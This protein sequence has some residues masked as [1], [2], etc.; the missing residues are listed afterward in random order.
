LPYLAIKKKKLFHV[1]SLW[2]SRSLTRKN[3][4]HE[5]CLYQTFLLAGWCASSWPQDHVTSDEFCGKNK[6]ST[7]APWSYQQACAP[8]SSRRLPAPTLPV[9][10]FGWAQVQVHVHVQQHCL[11]RATRM[12]LSPARRASN[13]SPRG[14]R[15]VV[16][17]MPSWLFLYI[18]LHVLFFPV[19]FVHV[20]VHV[21][22]SRY[23]DWCW[24]PAW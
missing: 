19:C 23:V 8:A 15:A 7:C 1:L 14:W 12:T 13:F 20:I 9:R 3:Q 4:C 16:F 10:H 17:V 24:A 22:C 11:E 18:W 6:T 5:A 2:L 21:F